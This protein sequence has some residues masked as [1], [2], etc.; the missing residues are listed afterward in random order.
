MESFLFTC[1]SP[2]F[3]AVSCKCGTL[4][5][6]VNTYVSVRCTNLSRTLRHSEG[7]G[8]CR[9]HKW[10]LYS[11]MVAVKRTLVNVEYEE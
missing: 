7:C 6:V 5:N 8:L 3:Y 11:R 4:W 9:V 10:H 1:V 2:F